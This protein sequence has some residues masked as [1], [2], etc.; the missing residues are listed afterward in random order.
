MQVKEM[1]VTASEKASRLS[2]RLLW[3]IPL[4]SLVGFT[5]ANWLLD[6]AW[7]LW[8]VI[9]LAVILATPFGLGAYQGLRAFRLGNVRA[10]IPMAVHAAFVVLALVMPVAEALTY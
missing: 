8:Q 3:W 1:P 6:E 5:T 7:P 9:P 2:W 10:W 4:S